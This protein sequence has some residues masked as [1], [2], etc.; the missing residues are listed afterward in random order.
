MN[1]QSPRN[2]H[3]CQRARER[4]GIENPHQLWLDLC[5]ALREGREDFVEKVFDIPG[6]EDRNGIPMRSIWRFVAPSGE[7]FY[8]V[9]S[10]AFLIPVTILTHAQV[11]FYREVRRRSRPKGRK[12]S[13]P[14][15][16]AP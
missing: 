10:N 9:V 2:Q 4:A 16:K 15:K 13:R 8:A 5:K 1:D 7:I 11:A 12:G 3:F 6:Q 14:W